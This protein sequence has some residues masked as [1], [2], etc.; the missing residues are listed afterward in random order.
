MP[1]QRLSD[2]K[3]YVSEKYNRALPRKRGSGMEGSVF[4]GCSDCESEP[5]PDD[6]GRVSADEYRL[7][8]NALREIMGRKRIDVCLVHNSRDLYYYS[9]TAL[10]CTLVM[11]ANREPTLLVR[12]NLAQ[13]TQDS[14]ISDVRESTGLNE[15]G[16]AIRALDYDRPVIGY[17]E[18]VTPVSL[19]KKLKQMLPNADFVDISP[20]ILSQRMVK[21]PIE[22][23][24]VRRAALISGVGLKRAAAMLRV[25][26]SEIV[27]AAEMEV[28]KR[29]AGHDGLMTGRRQGVI[30]PAVFVASGRNTANVS[31]YWVSIIGPGPSRALPFGPSSRQLRRGDLVV[32]DHGTVYRGYHSD[33]GRTFVCGK[34]RDRQKRMFEVVRRAQDAAIGRVKPGIEASEVYLA[35]WRV[36]KDAGY[37]KY[38]MAYG[39]YGLEYL[40]HGLG[41]EIDEPP[42]IGPKTTTLLEEGMTLAIEPKLIVPGWGG[43]DIEDTV[44][45]T[46]DGCDVLTQGKREL[47]EVG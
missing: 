46:C 24:M 13:A 42:L 8:V 2:L 27:V 23:A 4:E 18:D 43:V 5:A 11:P 36:V 40:G 7:R 17:E 30:N 3:G 45:V 47:I 38:F 41:L 34:A 22:I 33:E 32:V 26:V 20:E 35:A 44:V 37:E 1:S 25:G 21:S 12:I 29:L 9:G 6:G 19:F 39:Q 16:Q 14:W 31:G 28:A 15:V 10:Y